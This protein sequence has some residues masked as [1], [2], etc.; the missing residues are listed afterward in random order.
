MTAIDVLAWAGVALVVAFVVLVIALVV[1]ATIAAIK[2]G[3]DD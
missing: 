2:E 3:N 1:A